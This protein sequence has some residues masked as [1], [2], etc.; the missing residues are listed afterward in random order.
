MRHL[1]TTDKPVADQF[2][3]WR[4]VILEACT[5]L[6]IEREP[7]HRADGATVS[8]FLGSL[9]FAKLMST[10]CAEVNSQ[11][12]SMVHG[13]A[14]VRR[15]LSADVFISLQVGGECH[16]VQDN[17]GC[18]LRPGGFAMFDTTRPYRLNHLG[19]AADGTWQT[20]SFRVPRS[21]LAPLVRDPQSF[22]AVV[23]DAT[24][25]GIAAVAAS[26]MTGIWRT[27]DSL[28]ALAAQAAESALV[29]LLAATVAGHVESG[30]DT[31]AALRAAVHRY[32]AANLHSSDLT[33]SRV[34]QHLGISVRKLHGL[35]EHSEQTYA[36]TVR[37]LRLAACARE[38]AAG[39]RRRTLTDTAARWG[40]A[41]L[42][43][44]NRTFR[45]RYGCLPS[46]YRAAAGASG[47]TAR[48]G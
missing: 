34:A 30:P 12:Q 41:D 5:P 33:A 9:R 10:N 38:L 22:T 45:A 37:T 19:D 7:A 42:S 13:A 18:H 47:D 29:T 4:E 17:R 15:Q 43:H 24:A 1:T 25:G 44:L 11:R 26:T 36:Q 23:H 35:Y 48:T 3:Y 2:S 21:R 16:A 40:F 14:E 20:L 6:D 27:V 39:D 28:D 31:D 32:L 8:G 46:E